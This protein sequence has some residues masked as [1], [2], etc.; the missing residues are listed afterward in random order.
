MHQVLFQR[1]AIIECPK[2][3]WNLGY[4]YGLISRQETKQFTEIYG[5]FCALPEFNP[6]GHS[7]II[8]QAA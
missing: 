3:L 5:L 4:F 1:G 2:W 8:R 6:T 7:S